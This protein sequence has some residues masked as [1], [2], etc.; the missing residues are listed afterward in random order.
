MALGE[1]WYGAGRQVNNFIVINL[2]FGIGSGIIIDGKPL[3]GP[4][5]MAGELGHITVDKNSN[6]RCA[7]GNY[8]CIEALASGNAIAMH[9]IRE[10][11]KNKDNLIHKLS[12]GKEELITAELVARAVKE[13]DKTASK[14]WYEAIDHIGTT[15]ASMINLISPELVLI[16]G[17]LAQSEDLIFKRIEE[18]VNKRAMLTSIRNVEIRPVTF[19]MQA[20]TKGAASLILN[21]VLK[22]NYSQN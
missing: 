18:I 21:E 10:L 3:Y 14:I 20:A 13:G 17:G 7:C 4:F 6:V 19:G 12:E 22:L 2:G 16:G 11:K 9:A 8:G 1:L 15:I 5:G